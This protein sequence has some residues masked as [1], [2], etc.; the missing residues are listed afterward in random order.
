MNVGR[1][2]LLFRT[3]PGRRRRHD[4]I[5]VTYK[6]RLPR[7][8]VRGDC[9]HTYCTGHKESLRMFDAFRSCAIARMSTSTAQQSKQ[10]RDNILR[11][12]LAYACP[13][14]SVAPVRREP[15]VVAEVPK[16]G[17]GWAR[18]PSS[19]IHGQCRL[20]SRQ[21][22]TATIAGHLGMLP[23]SEGRFEFTGR[24]AFQ[25]FQPNT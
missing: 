23:V 2:I 1:N 17:L 14:C 9:G 11:P 25:P 7:A 15:G 13:P 10:A 22:D 12:I 5:G 3:P 24:E 4:S 19:C 8:G 16:R 20:D 18:P 21:G 6:D